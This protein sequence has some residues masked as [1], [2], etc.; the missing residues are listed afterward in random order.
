MIQRKDFACAHYRSR[1]TLQVIV[2]VSTGNQYGGQSRISQCFAF[3]LY[4]LIFLY[5]QC[6]FMSSYDGEMFEDPLDV[7]LTKNWMCKWVD[8]LLGMY[9]QI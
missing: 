7:F 8:F 3:I 6:D 9:V 2:F 5:E 4:Y 1:K